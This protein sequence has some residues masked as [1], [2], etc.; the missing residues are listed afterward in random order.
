MSIEFDT[1]QKA[2]TLAILA[3]VL[4]LLIS[5]AASTCQASAGRTYYVAT[6]GLDTNP[7]TL[8]QPFRTIG[9]GASVLTPGDTLY[10]K[11]GTYLQTTT[12]TISRSG[13]ST[14]PITIAT[15]PGEPSRAIISGDTNGNRISDQTD[16]PRPMGWHLVSLEGS[17]IH[18]ENLE[19]AFSGE[20]GVTSFGTNNVI[21]GNAIHDIWMSGYLDRG[22]NNVIEN[23][24]IWRTAEKN[25][26]GGVGGSRGCNGD[27]P[28]ALAWGDTSTATANA[29]VSRNTVVR[30]NTV[31]NN[32]GEGILCMHTQG[33]VVEDNVIYDNWALGIYLDQCSN[34]TIQRNLLYYT[35]DTKWWRGGTYPSDNIML[36]NEGISNFPVVGH[37]R[38][39]INNILVG[40]SFRFWVGW[41]STS[42]MV[43]DLIANNTIVETQ[44]NFAISI[45]APGTATSHANTRFAN[46]LILQSTKGMANVS[47][48]TGLTFDHNLW[49]RTPPS[50]VASATD[51]IGNPLLANPNHTRVPGAVNAAWYRPTANSPTINR[52]TAVAS[53]LDD[54]SQVTRPQGAGYD[55]G[56]YEYKFTVA[57]DPNTLYLMIIAR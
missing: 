57:N 19:I 44:N 23:N 2:G 46:N 17:Y 25:Y 18:L 35:S 27:W 31:F 24:T 42:A 14:A 28:G 5:L 49:S 48:T 51:V 47:T 56:A 43:N 38:K 21:S 11:S 12:L 15:T 7:G 50:N 4:I 53:V 9:K 30:R 10:I 34:M 1:R 20:Y 32:S 22:A 13:T 29:E 3:A 37:D 41:M 16:T 33:G 26:C 54:F 6:N 40:S 8:A 36:S 39:V 52:G 45:D 55:I